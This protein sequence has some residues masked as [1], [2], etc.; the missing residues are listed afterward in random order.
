[1]EIKYN[2]W[3][4]DA[5]TGYDDYYGPDYYHPTPLNHHIDL[6]V[7]ATLTKWDV[8][9][10]FYEKYRGCRVVHIVNCFLVTSGVVTY[11]HKESS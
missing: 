8:F 9:D 3:H 11:E 10:M 5:Y 4:I 2:I 7:N 6:I 1:M